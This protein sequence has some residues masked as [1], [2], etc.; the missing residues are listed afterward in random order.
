MEAHLQELNWQKQQI[1]YNDYQ[2]AMQ[3]KDFKKKM[4]R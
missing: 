3:E 1:L 2:R 4:E